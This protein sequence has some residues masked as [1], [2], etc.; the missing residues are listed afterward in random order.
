MHYRKGASPHILPHRKGMSYWC[1]GMALAKGTGGRCNWGREHQ[2]LIG[3][4]SAEK[5][6]KFKKLKNGKGQRGAEG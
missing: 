5:Y 1:P 3:N 4:L 2:A 6:P